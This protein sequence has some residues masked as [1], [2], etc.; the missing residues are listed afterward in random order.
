MTLANQL[1]LLRICLVP[2]LVILV[3][4]GY[5]GWALALFFVAALTDGLDGIVARA[6]QER[7]SLGAI[8]DPLA[9]KLLTTALLI[10]LALPS[11]ELAARVPPWIAIIS[12]GRDAAILLAFLVFHLAGV[13][14]SIQPSFLGKATTVAHLVVLLW[15][16][17]CNYRG[18]DHPLTRVLLWALLGLVLV[19]GAHYLYLGQRVVAQESKRERAA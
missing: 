15:I 4:Y 7:T 12:I 9:D 3:V 14:G 19:S 17:G 6:R 1:T 16:L 2:A 11:P 5:F 10:V 13:K 8:L 18:E